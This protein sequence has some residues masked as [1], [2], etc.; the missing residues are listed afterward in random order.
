MDQSSGI[1][2]NEAALHSLKRAQ[3][4]TLC[5]RYNLKQT[6]KNEELI[7]RLQKY[8]ETLRNK[9]RATNNENRVAASDSSSQE[10]HLRTSQ[11]WELVEGG[12]EEENSMIMDKRSRT[13][14]LRSM[15][16]MGTVRSHASSKES[17]MG[18]VS[19]RGT[20][21]SLM[22]LATS[23]KRAGSKSSKMSF[24]T[25][26]SSMSATDSIVREPMSHL[27]PNVP[28]HDKTAIKTKDDT[29][30]IDSNLDAGSFEPIQ[31]GTVDGTKVQ[32]DQVTV[33]LVTSV[34]DRAR[35]PVTIC[36]TPSLKPFPSLPQGSETRISKSENGP[37][38]STDTV[39]PA[40]E[41]SSA[42]TFSQSVAVTPKK[43]TLSEES[44]IS[45]LK[46]ASPGFVFGS[47]VNA[48]SNTQFNDVAASIL[49]EMNMRMGIDSTS[50]AAARVDKDG[51]INFGEVSPKG[52]A[53]TITF[54][55]R[56]G[57]SR[58]G[59]VHQKEFEKMP[60]IA[61]HY[62]VKHS[63]PLPKAGTKRM[64]SVFD[65]RTT[66]VLTGGRATRIADSKD[67]SED[68]PAPKRQRLDNPTT[69]RGGPL[70]RPSASG[71][72][73]AGGLKKRRESRGSKG[74]RSSGGPSTATKRPGLP[75]KAT[76]MGR[77]GLLRDGAAK[78]VKTI[79]S[80][81]KNPS[82]P[83]ASSLKTTNQTS[84]AAGTN[85]AS[86]LNGAST[87]SPAVVND[88]TKSQASVRARQPVARPSSLASRNNTP[89][90]GVTQQSVSKSRAP[91]LTAKQPVRVI[92]ASAAGMQ[93]GKL[94]D[95][96]EA[97][98]SGTSSISKRTST[99]SSVSEKQANAGETGQAK[100][101]TTIPSSSI[102]S[103][104]SAG[105]KASKIGA[106]EA[107]PDAS[108]NVASKRESYRDADF[109]P[110]KENDGERSRSCSPL[111][112][113]PA[114]LSSRPL[115]RRQ[116]LESTQPKD[117]T[118][119]DVPSDGSLGRKPRI[120]RS[121]VIA[122]VHESRQRSTQDTAVQKTAKPRKS[123]SGARKSLG[124]GAKAKLMGTEAA[125]GR[126]S[127]IAA[128]RR[129]TGTEVPGARRRT[130]QPKV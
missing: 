82:H 105:S 36:S 96:Q 115:Q 99:I 38:R 25:T 5:K 12:P 76:P 8:A 31:Q 24:S 107:M 21:S 89:A 26:K 57:D 78:V 104:M 44:A 114:S 16:S 45:Q 59:L 88:T 23:L 81:V 112:A 14:S 63:A 40:A 51:T 77:L 53:S 32:P 35:D 74:R 62:S 4:M 68:A 19:S 49:A 3:L 79:F 27:F 86:R 30:P 39:I 55:K 48:V 41:E 118:G 91:S 119:N 18:S 87:Q 10:P 95:F 7:N 121:K 34:P 106:P 2:F 116:P 28:V 98:S 11:Q 103:R 61:D 102:S 20:G 92:R 58:F 75:A 120:S 67:K 65:E 130:I 52:R 123:I 129:P 124:T 37:S 110:P 126:A 33:R 66:T 43:A 60:S 127:V 100:A 13:T 46:P 72:N 83:Q 108:D 22:S 101:A 111:P 15:M 50:S 97:T 85:G 47:P 9:E 84:S 69:A 117:V 128:R 125:K 94:P 71:N 122:K 17:N 42:A 1:L 93:R 54:E 90:A 109:D 64:S 113:P 80:S 73:T 56:V 6:G 29:L 70:A